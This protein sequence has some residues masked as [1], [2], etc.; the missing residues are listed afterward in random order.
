MDAVKKE[1]SSCKVKLS[2]YEKG[3][4]FKLENGINDGA[5]QNDT[6][7]RLTALKEA[8]LPMPSSKNYQIVWYQTTLEG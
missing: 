7:I 8:V 5:I 3:S 2:T 4:S 1:L 6:P